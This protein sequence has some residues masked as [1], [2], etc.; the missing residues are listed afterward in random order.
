MNDSKSKVLVITR[1]KKISDEAIS[2]FL[3]NE[4]LEQTD[5]LKYLGIYFDKKFKFDSHIEQLHDK[6]IRLIH[7]LSKSAKLTWGLGNKALTT[8]YKGAIEPILTYGAPVWGAALKRQKNLKKLQ[9]IQRLI[10]IKITKAY[11]TISY[12]ASCV[13]AAIQPIDITIQGKLELYKY[14]HEVKDYDAPLKP[15]DWNH[16]AERPYIKEV[17]EDV[18]YKFNIYTDGSKIGEKVG[19]AAV[20]FQNDIPFQQLKYR[21]GRKCSNN[22]AEQLAIL[23][24]LQELQNIGDLP[25]ED[26]T[27]A[28]HS[29]SKVALAI[30]QDNRKHN[31][32]AEDSLRILKHLEEKQ[33][34]IHFRWVKAH[35]GNPGNELADKMAKEAASDE[36][37]L[38]VYIKVPK[39][40][41][42]TEIQETGYQQW[43]SRWNTT[44]NGGICKAFFPSIKDRL[45]KRLPITPNFTAIVSGHGKTKAYLHRFHIIDDPKCTCNNPQQTVYHLI[46]ECKDTRPQR[47]ILIAD[48][49][50]NGGTWPA[51][52]Q[53]LV[54]R[55]LTAFCKYI[56]TLNL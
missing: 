11:R 40:T 16:P 32:L 39:S 24:A 14:T 43:Q 47:A 13:I 46:Y 10:N 19:A 17:E 22:Q 26:K 15:S 56:H 27:A 35:V 30:L 8:I 7:S 29:D 4:T 1:K 48:I 25:N 12:D 21:L 45:K 18:N 53:Q 37:L 31:S 2:I 38:Q 6:S 5:V 33:W 20:L 42:K 44:K 41:I 55:Y 36:E 52:T 49:R 50:R 9:R 34:R 51:T 28:I 23:K 54:T 3:N